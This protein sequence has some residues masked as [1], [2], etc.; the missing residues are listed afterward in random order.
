VGGWRPLSHSTR[1]RTVA[2]A[3][4]WL[5]VEGRHQPAVR[6]GY[7]GPPGP[8]PADFVACRGS[9]VAHSA[10]LRAR[11]A[12]PGV[13]PLSIGP[14]SAQ[15]PVPSGPVPGVMGHLAF[16]WIGRALPSD[17]AQLP[18][19]ETGVQAFTVGVFV[20]YG[21]VSDASL[22]ALDGGIGST[23]AAS[24]LRQIWFTC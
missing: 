1:D 8:D 5:R 18:Y 20:S 14:M 21:D 3:S 19:P 16:R 17:L 2:L 6:I 12:R 11:N 7:E 9:R 10:S 23:A 13:Q 22:R 4:P 15:R 24:S